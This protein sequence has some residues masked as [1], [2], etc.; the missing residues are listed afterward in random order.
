M[1]ISI[2]T[3]QALLCQI[4]LCP[5]HL[6]ELSGGSNHYVFDAETLEGKKLIIKF[7]RIRKTERKYQKGNQDT[8][9]GGELSME[10]EG[11]LLDA[12]RSAGIPTPRV[13]GIYDSAQ[14]RCIVMERS[15]G[16]NLMAYMTE[17]RHSLTVFLQVMQRL[18]EDLRNLH[19]F[20]YPSF[21]NL[22]QGGLVEPA[23]IDNFADRYLPINDRLITI[24]RDKGGLNA[25][26]FER[27]TSFF[28]ER[29]RHFRSVLDIAVSPATLVITDLHGGNFFVENQKCS[30]YFDVESAQ[31]APAAFELYA[32]RFFVFNFYGKKEYA[33]AQEAFW[34]A[35]Y[36]GR[37]N[38]PDPQTDAL[39]DFFSACRL[40]ELCQS[41]WGYVDG[42]RDNWGEEIKQILFR[43]MAGKPLDY[44][45]LGA[46]WRER[47]GQPGQAQP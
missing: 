8:L 22:M 29:F 30:G 4:G 5:A 10:R 25:L 26:E 42:L 37:R 1:S 28:N 32:M 27:V 46:I 34:H 11:Y 16:M 31:A 13:I 15:P 44:Q 12:V 17:N 35:Y 24:C 3:V 7:P 40:L 21:G 9:F 20:R 38:E 19:T 33:L 6:R 36:A 2:Q 47:D 45:H 41:Y 39:I 18:G 23:G 43:Y 14:G